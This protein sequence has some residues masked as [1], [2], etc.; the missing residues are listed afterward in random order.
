MD[1]IVSCMSHDHA[2]R[3]TAHNTE[4]RSHMCANVQTR[5]PQP[6]CKKLS[7]DPLH[8]SHRTEQATVLRFFGRISNSPA[9]LSDDD[10]EELLRCIGNHFCGATK[11]EANGVRGTS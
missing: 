11:Q 1:R 4:A 8:N 3:I 5:M 6:N 9:A 2:E 7:N 10:R